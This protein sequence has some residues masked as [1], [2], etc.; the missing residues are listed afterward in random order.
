MMALSTL[1]AKAAM[2]ADQIGI[3]FIL[4]GTIVLFIWGR[5]RH[6]LVAA[7]ALLA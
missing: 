4:L 5:F 7:A 6:D 1:P 3:L 2:S